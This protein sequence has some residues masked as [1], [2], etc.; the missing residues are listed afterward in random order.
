MNAIKRIGSVLYKWWMLFARALAFINTRVLLTLF[1]VIVIGPIALA[2]RA[3]GK[4]FLERRIDSSPSYWKTR[5]TSE[6]S[7]E[8]ASHQF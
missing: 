2:L 7:L 6:H 8:S 1:F 5:G 3:I 4:D